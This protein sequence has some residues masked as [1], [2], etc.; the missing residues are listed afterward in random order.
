MA[1]YFGMPKLLRGKGQRFNLPYELSKLSSYRTLVVTKESQA[2]IGNL[3]KLLKAFYNNTA[4]VDTL[5]CS[6]KCDLE[7]SKKIALHYEKAHA[8]C[9]VVLGGEDIISVACAAKNFVYGGEGK[10]DLSVSFPIIAVLNSIGFTVGASLGYVQNTQE[11]TLVQYK[12]EAMLPDTVIIDDALCDKPP[13]YQAQLAIETA[14]LAYAADYGK[15]L[16]SDAIFDEVKNGIFSLTAS[17]FKGRYKA[18]DLVQMSYLTGIAAKDG[19]PL[20]LP[21]GTIDS[22]AV[23][24]ALLALD[25]VTLEKLPPADY[26]VFV[27]KEKLCRIEDII[28]ILCN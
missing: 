21:N 13:F 9:I 27:N 18:A 7:F 1:Q 28:S 17:L 25:A 23:T 10:V 8:D 6:D 15:S 12:T 4:P 22:N 26:P 14:I 3:K 2:R 16:Y 24:T 20:P 11:Q 5:I 19:L